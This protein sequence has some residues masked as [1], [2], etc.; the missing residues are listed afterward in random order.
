M[1]IHR[2]CG[3]AVDRQVHVPLWDRW[4]YQCTGPGCQQRGTAWAPPA[5]PCSACGAPLSSEREEAV[6]D[7]E[8]RTATAPRTFFDVTVR[9][10]VPGNAQRASVAASRDG[11]VAKEAE[12]TKKARYPDGQTPW[13]CVPLATETFGRHGGQAL[14]HLRELAKA[15]VAGLDDGAERAAGALVQRWGAQLAVALHRANAAVLWAALRPERVAA[16]TPEDV[17]R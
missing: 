16:S 4:H 12:A 15:K 14:K 9:Y 6:L 5:A 13:R 7:L 1:K 17:T 10:S 2:E 8:V 3:H 11:A